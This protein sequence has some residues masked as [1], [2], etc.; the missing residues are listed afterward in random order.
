MAERERKGREPIRA[1]VRMTDE[2][3][4]DAKWAVE[5]RGDPSVSHI[6]RTFLRSYVRDAKAAARLQEARRRAHQQRSEPRDGTSRD[7]EQAE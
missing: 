3:W 4:A 1:K 2:E 5:W 7:R 6:I